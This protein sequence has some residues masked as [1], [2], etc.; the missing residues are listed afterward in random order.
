MNMIYNCLVPRCKGGIESVAC[1]Y[2]FLKPA[3]DIIHVNSDGNL[4]I[5]EMMMNQELLQ[6]KMLQPKLHQ[7]II[8][9][10]ACLQYI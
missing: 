5:Q 1:K 8:L 3:C 4:L 10:R 7:L 6:L 9:A 2:G